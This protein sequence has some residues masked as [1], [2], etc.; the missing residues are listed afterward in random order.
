MFE[1]VPEPE[2]SAWFETL[3]DPFAEEVASAIDLTASAG[4]ALMPQ[5]LSRLLLW[6][7]GTGSG[8]TLTACAT[9]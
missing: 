8:S 7:D 2:F 5:R 3:P 4:P 1:V 9:T 6:Y